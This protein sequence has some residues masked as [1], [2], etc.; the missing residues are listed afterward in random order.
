MITVTEE[1]IGT[2]PYVCVIPEGSFDVGKTFDCGQ[3]FRFDRVEGSRHEIEY[4]GVAYGKA[5]SF[6]SDGDRLYIYN[7]TAEEYERLWRHYL[8]LDM[9]YSAIDRDL[10]L[11]CE[12]EVSCS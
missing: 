10:L 5:V 1:R 11:H 4:S 8:G 12:S 3:S 6:A 7:S 2:L 9:D